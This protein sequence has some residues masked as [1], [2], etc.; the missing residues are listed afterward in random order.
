MHEPGKIEK[1]LCYDVLLK[2][3]KVFY[4]ILL[5]TKLST[6]LTKIFFKCFSFSFGFKKGREENLKNANSG[7]QK[8]FDLFLFRFSRNKI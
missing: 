7:E 5:L 6:S 3:N 1:T 2:I 4:S 8:I